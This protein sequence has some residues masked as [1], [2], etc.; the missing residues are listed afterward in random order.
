METQKDLSKMTRAEVESE[1]IKMYKGLVDRMGVT[2]D[3]NLLE[4]II[5][6]AFGAAV[7]WKDKIE[8]VEKAKSYREGLK[9]MYDA[10]IDIAECEMD[11]KEFCDEMASIKEELN[12]KYKS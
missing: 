5:L 12:M 10:V 7:Q 6:N 3:K 4:T 11:Y 9:D 2:I 1:A 8:E